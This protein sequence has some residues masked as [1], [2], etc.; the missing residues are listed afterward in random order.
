MRT[1]VKFGRTD[2][3]DIVADHQSVSRAHARFVLD[4][5]HW[6]VIDNKS[7]NGV[8]VNGDE[9]A[10]SN[11][12]PGDV[13]E[14]GHLK[15]RFC[16]PGEKFTLPPEKGEDGA[17]KGG[18]KPTTAELIAGAQGKAPGARRSGRGAKI[19]IAVVAVLGAAGAGAYL[20]A[21]SRL[22]AG[23]Q[24]ARGEDA[25]K[26]GDALLKQH[27]YVSALEMYEKAGTS[28]APNRKKAADE[29]RGE[30]SY[31]AL[32]AALAAGD[33]DKARTLYDHCSAESTYW[34]QQAQDQAD[35]VKAAYAKKH[36]DGARAAKSAGKVEGCTAEANN[37]LAFDSGN[38]EAQ[39]LLSQ[40]R[41]QEAAKIE[42]AREEGPSP[43][44]REAKASRLAQ[45]SSNKL[46]ARDF[47]GAVKDAQ[48]AL[49]HS[50]KEKNTLML[51][52]RSLGYGYA[53]LN[54]KATA[55]KWLEKYLPYC[56]ND[57]D[58]VHAFIGK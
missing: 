3:N 9:Y 21:R 40:C 51:A 47:S 4:D 45:A 53:Y 7:A 33:A 29:A 6:K 12:K 36:L 48:A 43:K 41:P 52:Y 35:Q 14:L 20:F 22:P 5:G 30:E 16:A 37:V 32:R 23:P 27:K 28:A 46:V 24:E 44:E 13:L 56:S 34:C 42:S 31:N 15:F 19:A 18:L 58:Q 10:I 11:L 38:A 1:E 54:D 49:S 57:C 2:E 26:A 8:R 39:A 17:Q 55:V 50:P 25:V